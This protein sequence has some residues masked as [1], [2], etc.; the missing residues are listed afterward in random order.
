MTNKQQIAVSPSVDELI[1]Q[2]QSEGKTAQDLF[3]EKLLFWDVPDCYEEERLEVAFRDGYVTVDDG[4]VINDRTKINNH[5]RHTTVTGALD[6]FIQDYMGL[7]TPNR[8]VVTE[9]VDKLIQAYKAHGNTWYMLLKNK[10]FFWGV[11]DKELKLEYAFLYGYITVNNGIVVNERL[12]EIPYDLYESFDAMVHSNEYSC[13]E[14]YDW[15]QYDFIH[16][17]V[18]TLIYNALTYGYVQQERLY[19]VVFL[20]DKY[21]PSKYV[22]SKVIT[23][24]VN[25]AKYS[26]IDT[27]QLEREGISYTY[28][29]NNDNRDRTTLFTLAEIKKN[30]PHYYDFI[31]L[32]KIER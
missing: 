6:K 27:C 8:I 23:T 9:Q 28:N 31:R 16:L 19:Q 10:D 21:T 2:Y 12:T 18:K 17:N 1:Q 29:F 7:D 13:E 30:N 15:L 4:V 11:K 26:I 22:L 25:G 20:T 24:D 32:V 14:I 5:P 3:N